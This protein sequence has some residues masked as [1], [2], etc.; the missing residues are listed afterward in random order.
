[1]LNKIVHGLPKVDWV[2][3]KRSTRSSDFG[4]VVV[5]EIIREINSLG[6]HLSVYNDHLTLS[7]DTTTLTL[8]RAMM[9]KLLYD[10][11]IQMGLRL[12]TMHPDDLATWLNRYRC[13]MIWYLND[14]A[15]RTVR[16]I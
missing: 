5:K 10:A 12:K 3:Y 9:D 16:L 6:W 15:T 11:G 1:M 7:S 4:R 13:Y 8:N 2:E 14:K